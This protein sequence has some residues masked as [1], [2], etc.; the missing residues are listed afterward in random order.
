MS[1]DSPLAAAAPADVDAVSYAPPASPGP[2]SDRLGAWEAARLAVDASMATPSNVLGELRAIHGGVEA[3]LRKGDAAAAD[4]K[5]A[6]RDSVQLQRI[7]GGLEQ[8]LGAVT[9]ATA[10]APEQGAG[11]EA[12]LGRLTAAVLKAGASTRR[13]IQTFIRIPQC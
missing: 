2:D 5:A 7:H 11:H 13:C 9:A 8:V 1:A 4:M 6:E 12:A 10:K 3:L